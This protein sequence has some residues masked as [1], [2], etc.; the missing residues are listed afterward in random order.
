MCV[1]EADRGSCTKADTHNKVISHSG[2]LTPH[3][4][5]FDLHW[6]QSEY[7]AM[8]DWIRQDAQI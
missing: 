7:E 5:G 8:Y 6:T 1:L 4:L 2:K 3:W